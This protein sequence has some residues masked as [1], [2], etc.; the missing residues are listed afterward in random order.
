[1]DF[2]RLGLVGCGGFGRYHLRT[3]E[4]TSG[5]NVAALCDIDPTQF[6]R[7]IEQVPSLASVPQFVSMEAMVEAGGLD[8]VYLVTPHTLHLPQ[9][10][11]AFKAG[12]HVACE[13]PLCHTVADCL[14]AIAARDAA[15]TVGLLS[16]QRHTSAE[17]RWVRK[18]VMDGAIGTVQQAS[19]LLCQEWKRF[20][21]NTWRQVPALSGAGMLL[22]SG[23]HMLDAL[24]W[25]TGLEPEAVCAQV[26]F[27]GTPVEINCSASIR[28]RGGALGSI[29]VCGDAPGWREEFTVWGTE[30]MILL[31]DGK[32][33]MVDKSGARLA[34]E[35]VPGGSTPDQNFI[36][37]ILGK[38]EVHSPFE[39]GLAVMRLT[40]AVYRSAEQGGTAVAV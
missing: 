37:A 39:S 38:D 23:S 19:V 11:L 33:S 40:E 35:D 31:R 20:T 5:V 29:T 16:Y 4:K 36:D 18:Q 15:D 12:L 13:K 9:M 25:C 3:L 32:I 7:A 10:E 1:M 21:A 14:R 27:R 34:V 22:D 8:A 26:E 30:G 28:F 6:S 17:Y 2:V 24:L